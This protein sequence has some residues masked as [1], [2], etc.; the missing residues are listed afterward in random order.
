MNLKSKFSSAVF[1]GSHI[2]GL[3]L[4]ILVCLDPA[5]GNRIWK[6]GRYA[7][8]QFI[9]AGDYLVVQSEKG[10][11]AQVLASSDQFSETSRIEA[12]RHRTWTHPVI[13]SGVLLIRNDREMAA[14]RLQKQ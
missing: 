9:K 13:A 3:D 4:G 6:N 7:H 5:T 11:V 10:Y 1:D 12:F 14:Y 2:Y 8:G